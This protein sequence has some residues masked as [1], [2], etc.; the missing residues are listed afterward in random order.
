VNEMTSYFARTSAPL[1]KW[2]PFPTRRAMTTTDVT[3]RH[4]ASRAAKQTRMRRENNAA[5]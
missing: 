1:W 5:N 2:E 4:A 3:R